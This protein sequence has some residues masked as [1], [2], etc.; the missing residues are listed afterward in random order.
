MGYGY[1]SEIYFAI[2]LENEK[3]MK[4]GETTNGRRRQNQLNKE[5]YYITRCFDVEGGEAARLF[6]ESYL[7]MKLL[8]TNR[9]AQLRKD[10]FMCDCLETRKEFQDCFYSWVKEAHEIL[11]RM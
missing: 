9:V 8:K 1:Y 4:I 7:R 2:H 5:D 10:Y 6:V 11:K 3:M